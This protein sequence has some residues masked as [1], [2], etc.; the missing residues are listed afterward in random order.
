MLQRTHKRRFTP[1]APHLARADAPILE[2]QL[3]KAGERQR[4]QEVA[5]IDVRLT[6]AFTSEGEHGIRPA[7]NTALN[8]PREVHAQKWKR[9]FGDWINQ[10]AA[11]MLGFRL[12]LVIL[13]AERNNL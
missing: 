5:Q 4:L 2:R 11:Q 1:G 9:R 10:I 12:E 7:L 3:A 13:A 6:I 8:H